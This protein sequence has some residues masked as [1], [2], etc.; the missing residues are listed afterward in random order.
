MSSDLFKNAAKPSEHEAYILVE[1]E[2]QNAQVKYT[3]FI[4]VKQ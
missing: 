2:K 1:G 4:K 3:W